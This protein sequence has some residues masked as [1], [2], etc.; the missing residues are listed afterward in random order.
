MIH[1]PSG[2]QRVYLTLVDRAPMRGES[3]VG[4]RLDHIDY[5]TSGAPLA[6]TV[7]DDKV[8]PPETVIVAWHQVRT[9]RFLPE[10]VAAST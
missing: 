8:D 7:I 4:Y 2:S 1:R 5:D 3:Y 9:I 6:V 10:E